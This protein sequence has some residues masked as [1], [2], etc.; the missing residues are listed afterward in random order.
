M[1]AA[2]HEASVQDNIM[3][4]AA[5]P[6]QDALLGELLLATAI[7]H[8]KG[9]I[10]ITHATCVSSLQ[11]SSQLVPAGSHMKLHRALTTHYWTFPAVT[12]RGMSANTS[13]IYCCA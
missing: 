13:V 1:W 5:Q 12:S 4:P 10:C 3:M 2:C 11:A 6:A 7:L 8:T 9:Q